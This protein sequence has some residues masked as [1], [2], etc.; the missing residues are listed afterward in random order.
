MHNRSSIFIIRDSQD[1]AFLPPHETMQ[2][3]T[4]VKK[5]NHG[6]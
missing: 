4:M 2:T 6:T 1:E 3:M 5:K